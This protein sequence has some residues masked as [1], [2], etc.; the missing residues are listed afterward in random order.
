MW[1]MEADA[2]A[3]LIERRLR[4]Y[5]F[6]EQAGD[7]P[8]RPL[9]EGLRPAA[10]L[11]P[12]VWHADGPSVLLTRRADHLL[13]HPGQVSFPGGKLEAADGSAEA[14]ALR[15]AREETGLAEAGVRVL[16]RLP[17]YVTVTDFVVTPVVGLLHPPLALDP[18]PDE[19]AEVFEVPLERL[20]DKSA[21]SRHDYVRDGVSGQYLVFEWRRHT[22]WGA[23]AAMSWMLADALAAGRDQ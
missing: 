4:A 12:L 10:V 2:A 13:S 20:L 9:K 1:S 23:T 22:I 18:A 7:L 8:R 3:G 15:E 16:G 11:V 6:T 19:V 17:D 21:Y 14:A 5:D